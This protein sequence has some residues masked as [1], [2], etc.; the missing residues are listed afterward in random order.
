[1]TRSASFGD[2]RRPL[3]RPEEGVDFIGYGEDGRSPFRGPEAFRTP[4][5]T[6]GLRARTAPVQKELPIL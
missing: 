6:I 4:T 3:D 2:G 5:G 1:M